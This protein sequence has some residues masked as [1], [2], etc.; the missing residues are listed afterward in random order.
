[1]KLTNRQRNLLKHRY[2]VGM[3]VDITSY[4]DTTQRILDWAQA[5]KSC[6]ICVANVHM[7]MEVYDNPAFASVVNSAALVTPDGMP[8]VWALTA[9][10][11]K[12]ASRVYG[13]TLTLYVCEAAAKAGIPIGLYGGTSESLGAFVKF[14][15]QRFPDLQIACKISPPFRPLTPEEDD[16]YT[17]Q[18][19][20]S[21]ARILFVGIGCPRQ[22]LWMAAHKNRIPAVTLGVGAAFDFHSG[23]VKQAPSWMQKRG[24]EWLF[25]L[26]MEPKRLWKRYFK[27]NPRFLLF[28]MMQWLAS[29]FGW[30]LFETNS[31][32]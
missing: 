13:P 17:Q 6:Y 31:L 32:D 16:A 26:I 4:E 11:V 30:R 22:E 27:H 3:R 14:L 9:L 1:M 12:N 8:L 7:T 2:I 18:I 19:V 24:M 10:G 29:K 5:R 20:E 21:G 23:R 25:R 28:F 15:H